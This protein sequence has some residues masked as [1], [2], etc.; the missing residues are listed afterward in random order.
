MLESRGCG[1]CKQVV[2]AR[3]E[4]ESLL[5]LKCPKKAATFAILTVSG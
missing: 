4:V 3:L 2:D 5:A 1:E